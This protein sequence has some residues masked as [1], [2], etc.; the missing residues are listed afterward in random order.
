MPL[1]PGTRIGSSQVTA[2]IGESGMGE[3]YCAR[4][5]TFDRDVALRVLPEAFTQ[6][7]DRLARFERETRAVGRIGPSEQRGVMSWR[8]AWYQGQSGKA[9]RASPESAGL[10]RTG[11]STHAR[12]QGGVRWAVDVSPR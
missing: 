12:H 11:G 1:E 2:K 9:E 3:V 5:T 4:D 10:N 7:P 8:G 6:D